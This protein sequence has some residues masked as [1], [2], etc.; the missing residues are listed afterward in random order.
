MAVPGETPV[1]T[2][3]GGA[4]R[5]RVLLAEDNVINQKL[6]KAML[7]KIGLTVEV[8]NNG[9]E[10]LALTAWQA[11][12]IVLMDCQ[13][14]VMDGYQATAALRRRE[15]EG[16]ARLPVVAMTANAMEGDR[17]QCL[18][19][20]MDDY[21]AKPYSRLQLEQVLKRWLKPWVDVTSEAWAE[22]VQVAPVA[23]E[24]RTVIDMKVLDN[25]RDLDPSGGLNLTRE[26]MQIYLN[27]S[28]ETVAQMEEAIAMGDTE[29]LRR[30]AHSLK[31]SSANVG[32]TTLSSLF[33]EVEALAKAAR[34]DEAG[35]AFKAVRQEYECVR[36]EIRDLLKEAA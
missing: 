34:L 9:E 2:L 5:G 10:A 11:F 27:S 3:Q 12:D 6:A 14:P 26:I 21:L 33:K 22:P 18:A 16:G 4:L 7:A 19:A 1:P 24:G 31:S 25:Y 13:M 20:G 15:A 29:A 28:M 36:A 35:S 8:A 23:D 30:G 32:A 17:E